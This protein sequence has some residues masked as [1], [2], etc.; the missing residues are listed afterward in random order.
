MFIK[1]LLPI[2]QPAHTHPPTSPRPASLPLPSSKTSRAFLSFPAVCSEPPQSDN[3]H[4]SASEA[5]SGIARGRQAA[6]PTE[7]SGA[8]NK[9]LANYHENPEPYPGAREGAQ[10]NRGG[11]W[12]HV[13]TRC[14]ASFLLPGNPSAGSCT[15]RPHPVPM[16]KKRRTHLRLVFMM[17]PL[18]WV[19][20]SIRRLQML[21]KSSDLS[22]SLITWG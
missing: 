8:A 19:F 18:H 21:F 12:G 10:K 11:V 1:L 7:T 4:T 16:A 9:T 17:M 2:P 5:F 13:S 14:Q 3:G 20:H 22:T 6:F 15:S